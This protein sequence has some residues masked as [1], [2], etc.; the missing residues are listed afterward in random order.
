MPNITKAAE[1]QAEADRLAKE[2]D[3][4]AAPDRQKLHL[5]ADILAGTRL[6]EFST[7]GGKKLLPVI[8][9]QMQKMHAWLVKLAG[10]I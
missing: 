1:A 9:E 6:P 4:A 5:F 8:T 10:Q 7:E 3:A 2:R